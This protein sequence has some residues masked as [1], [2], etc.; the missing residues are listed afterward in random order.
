M[1][2]TRVRS[3]PLAPSVEPADAQAIALAVVGAAL[4]FAAPLHRPDLRLIGTAALA[5]ALLW[6]PWLSPALIAAA[7]PYFFYGRPFVGPLSFSPPGLIL[8][9]GWLSVGAH[10]VSDRLRGVR[11]LDLA[12]PVTP[13]DAPL[14]L[15]LVAALA[16]LLVTEYLVLS[17]RELRAL[18]LE[19]VAFFWL[20]AVLRRHDSVRLAVVGFLVSETLL[21]GVAIAQVVFGWGGTAAEGVRRAQAWYPSPNHLALTLGRAWPFLLA[22][23]LVGP[24]AWRRVAWLAAGMVAIALLLSFSIGGWLGSAAALA[25]VLFAVGLRQRAWQLGGAAAIGLALVSGLALV[26]ALPERLNPLRQTGGFRLELWSSTVE[27]LR[28]HP[29]LGVGLDNF[30]YLYQQVYLHEGAA[31]EPNLSHPHNWLLHVWVELG[32]LGL[33]AFVWLVVIFARRARRALHARPAPWLVAGG[34][35][36]MTD[37]L[38][39]GLVDNS[40]F[41]VDLA[42]V[43]WLILATV[44]D[45]VEGGR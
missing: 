26:G 45:E 29:L 10:A 13:Y 37:M 32:V 19:P 41:L 21:A 31:A 5:I 11:S 27:M 38:V 30:A 25:V 9:V 42:F 18:I 23:A 39:H 12:W 35:G 24:F 28:D 16:S 1:A 14:V 22:L 4:A 7:L 20:L 40:Y 2:G 17:V 34:L 36:A 8:V 33:I 15:F 3:W 44:L 43:F 6:R